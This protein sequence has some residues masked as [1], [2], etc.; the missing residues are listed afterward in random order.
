MNSRRRMGFSEKAFCNAQSLS[1]CGRAV[2]E[3]W[4]TIG[5]AENKPQ[6]FA[7]AAAAMNAAARKRGGF[8]ARSGKSADADLR[9]LVGNF[10]FRLVR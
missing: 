9:L 5:V 4:R 8:K 1:L 6:V 3:K 10:T 2:I 7:A